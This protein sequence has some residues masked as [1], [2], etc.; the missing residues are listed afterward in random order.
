MD[1]VAL[2]A[3]AFISLIIATNASLTVP[4][5]FARKGYNPYLGAV[6][7]AVVGFGSGVLTAL[8]VFQL[9]PGQGGLGVL[10]ALIGGVGGLLIL[11]RWLPDRRHLGH[12]LPDGEDLRRNIE[13]R[14]VRGRISRMLYITSVVVA[15]LALATLVWTILDKTVGLVAVEYDVQP[16][17]LLIAGEPVGR[18]LDDLSRDELAAVLAENARVARLRVF[19]LQDVVNAPQETWAELSSQPV[20]VVLGGYEYSEDLAALPFNQLDEPQ[21]A[22]LLFLN[23]DRAGLEDLVFSEIINPQVIA[24]WTLWDSLVH[25]SDIEAQM[26][27]ESPHAVIEWRS[28]LSWDFV[29]SALDPRRPDTTGLRPALL[30]SLMI[31]GITIVFAFP[32][33]VGAAIYLEEY[34]GDNRLSRI[35]QTNISNL[36]GVPSIIYGMLGLAIFV[37]SFEHLT[38]GNALGTSTANGRTIFS[39]GLTL[40]L[41]ILP[42]IIINAQE[43]IRAVPSSLRQASLGLGATKW[44]TIWNHVLPYALPGIL[45]GTILAVSRAIGET[46]PLILVGAATYITQDPDGPFS[47]F[48]ALPMLIYR[49]TTLPQAEFRNAAAAAIVVLLILLLTLNSIAI[50]LRNRFTR[51]LS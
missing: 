11:L 6:L 9:L 10:G 13:A 12:A 15:L 36:A 45:T 1:R 27:A 23:L 47:N 2:V 31:I 17:D 22:R 3:A 4:P 8:V 46:A 41:L 50:I 37:R 24:S 28:W 26:A 48:T 18:P 35:I 25:R 30:G 34:A 32:I 51:R 14:H 42:V 44:Q 21:A 29:T 5:V 16:E 49:W 40:A 43:A 38:S 33:G 20:E 7:G 19:V 39:A